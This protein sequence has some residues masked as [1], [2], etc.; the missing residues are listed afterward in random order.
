MWMS[1]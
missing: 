1:E